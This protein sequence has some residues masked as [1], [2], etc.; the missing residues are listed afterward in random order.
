LAFTNRASVVSPD[1]LTTAVGGFSVY[2]EDTK[3]QYATEDAD[4]LEF[5]VGGYEFKI[6]KIVGGGGYTVLDSLGYTAIGGTPSTSADLRATT[7]VASASGTLDTIWVYMGGEDSGDSLIV[8]V[9]DDDESYPGTLLG[10][11]D[12]TAGNQGGDAWI[13]IPLSSSVSITNGVTYWVAYQVYDS[14][15][16][17]I[18]YNSVGTRYNVARVWDRTLPA[19]YPGS[20]SSGNYSYSIFGKIKE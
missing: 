4:T 11:S 5:N 12:V 19:T 20:G 3:I 14:G 10:S 16:I 8:G 9:Y 13:P 18:R 1:P 7:D 17:G 15:K 6:E 2:D